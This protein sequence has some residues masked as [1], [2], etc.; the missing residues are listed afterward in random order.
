M[1]S[2]LNALIVECVQSSS[3]CECHLLWIQQKKPI[4]RLLLESAN[5]VSVH[6]AFSAWFS[7]SF[8]LFFKKLC[9]FFAI[10]KESGDRKFQSIKI[11]WVGFFFP[12]KFWHSN[13][14]RTSG[15]SERSVVMWC[16]MTE[17][18]RVAR[19]FYLM[20]ENVIRWQ[21]P[22][23]YPVPPYAVEPSKSFINCT[24]I[25]CEI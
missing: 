6:L 2:N 12:A 21:V 23:F 14:E 3:E 5:Y 18:L 10:P 13:G 20:L 15:R 24:C 11:N 19:H 8:I 1:S 22:N 9:F 25:V 16:F 17:D 4:W 7:I